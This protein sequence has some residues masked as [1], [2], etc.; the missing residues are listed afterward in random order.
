MA[1]II[2]SPHDNTIIYAGYQKV[3][4]STTRGDKWEIMSPDLTKNDPKEM[5]VKNLQRHSLPDHRRAR[6]IAEEGGVDVRRERRRPVAHD[7]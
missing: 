7:D 4:K 5:L 1:P 6:R 3:F 2:I